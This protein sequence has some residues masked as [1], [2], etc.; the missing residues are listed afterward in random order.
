[1]S[2]SFLSFVPSITPNFIDQF[3]KLVDEFICHISYDPFD[4][5][6]FTECIDHILELCFGLNL[7]GISKDL[8]V[9]GL[10]DVHNISVCK[11]NIW[12]SDGKIQSM[13]QS[14]LGD[15]LLKTLDNNFHKFQG[16][17]HSLDGGK[18][19]LGNPFVPDT[20]DHIYTCSPF[21]E[22]DSVSMHLVLACFYNALWGLGKNM[23]ILH[24][25]L[26]GLYHDIGKPITVETIEFKNSTMTG[27]PAHAEIGC[28][29]FQMHWNPRM[30]KWISLSNFLAISNT[31]L[32]HMCGYHDDHNPRTFYKRELL[33]LDPPRVKLLMSINRVGDHFGKLVPPNNKEPIDHF[34]A[35]QS[36][37]ESVMNKQF[38]FQHI[39]NTRVSADGQKICN[40]K[41]LI[42]MIGKS[43]AGKT[44]FTNTLQQS[45]PHNFVNVISRDTCIANVTV[46]V[47]QRLIG[48]DYIHMYKIYEAG[49][50]LH[51]L[52]KKH[53]LGHK[54]SKK[55]IFEI[56]K[57]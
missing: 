30:A 15:L 37:F 32:R 8:L 35:Q 25:A 21:H 7:E 41:F 5:I 23:S 36:I 3:Q 17:C 12:T 49:K 18:C 11:T 6:K 4:E 9:Q 39:L 26:L 16:K 53:K 44:Y 20:S 46:G 42:F 2:D 1:M 40:S 47:N 19:R 48:T 54:L 56:Q 10:I 38:D 28:M 31:I 43:G 33:L 27:F 55:E 29:L 45:L 24:C 57:N 51:S 52:T 34:L 13:I 50:N 14:S 22:Y